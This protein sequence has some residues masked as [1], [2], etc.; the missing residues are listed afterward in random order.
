MAQTAE[1]LKIAGYSHLNTIKS[2]RIWKLTSSID[3]R[4]INL[5]S[6][7]L[8]FQCL[9]FD[10]HGKMASSDVGRFGRTLPSL[11]DTHRTLSS[12]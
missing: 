12:Y 5:S 7:L 3:C 1:M 9:S 4:H 11:A 8:S 10:K 2:E 6:L